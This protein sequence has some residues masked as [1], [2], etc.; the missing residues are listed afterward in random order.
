MDAAETRQVCAARIANDDGK[1]DQIAHHDGRKTPHLIEI[2]LDALRS[3]LALA[4][5]LLDAERLI[6]IQNIMIGPVS[7]G[8][9][10]A[11]S[12]NQPL[13]LQMAPGRHGVAADESP[14]DDRPAGGDGRPAEPA[15]PDASEPAA[16]IWY[17][18][19][20]EYSGR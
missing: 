16:G 4:R 12:Q 14:G 6:H 17:P 7:D 2:D 3:N 10:D 5:R 20:Y 18:D 19:R 1:A 15:S 13:A 9:D 8:V 11:L